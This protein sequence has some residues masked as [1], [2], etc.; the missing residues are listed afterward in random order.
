MNTQ[1]R[2][3]HS[4]Q[5]GVGDFL[6]GVLA[7]LFVGG[8]AGVWIGVSARGAELLGMPAWTYD[9][10]AFAGLG[11]VGLLWAAN[12]LG[13]AK[14]AAMVSRMCGA[15]FA[16]GACVFFLAGF[17]DD[18]RASGPVN[19]AK[20][21]R[22]LQRFIAWSA[23]VGAPAIAFLTNACVVVGQVRRANAY[24]RSRNGFR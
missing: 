19:F 11:A 3:A 5:Q 2:A 13:D 22:S 20:L 4:P 1:R 23:L 7:A 6:W 18:Q 21:A 9:F 8:M 14:D 10:A 15:F 12:R 17:F 24:T 16:V